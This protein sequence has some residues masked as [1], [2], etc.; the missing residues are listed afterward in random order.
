MHGRIV[1]DV[2]E[3][4]IK[5][6]ISIAGDVRDGVGEPRESFTLIVV[7]PAPA[8]VAS[9]K[10]LDLRTFTGRIGQIAFRERGY[11]GT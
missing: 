8:S 2:L 10:R 11:S 3:L 5:G 4:S 6:V 9:C 1:K 7:L